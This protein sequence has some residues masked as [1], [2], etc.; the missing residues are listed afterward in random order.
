VTPENLS[1]EEEHPGPLPPNNNNINQVSML[2]K[3]FITDEEAK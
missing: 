1:P 2:W 3:V